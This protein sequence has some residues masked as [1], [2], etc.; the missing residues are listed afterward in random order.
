MC[1]AVIRKSPV[2]VRERLLKTFII[3]YSI[4]FGFFGFLYRTAPP[5]S[6][7]IITKHMM[8]R[9]D[10]TLNVNLIVKKTYKYSILG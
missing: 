7:H 3:T 6:D 5:C 9:L 10:L 2:V 1:T 4:W 8:N